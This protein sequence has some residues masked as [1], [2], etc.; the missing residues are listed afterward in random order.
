LAMDDRVIEAV[1]QYRFEP[2][3]FRGKPVPVETTI[4]IQF[5]VYGPP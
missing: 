3:Q 5:G 2:A 4:G 1:K